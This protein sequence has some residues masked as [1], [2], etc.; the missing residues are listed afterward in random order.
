M[1]RGAVLGPLAL[2]AVLLALVLLQGLVLREERQ[3]R[4]IRLDGVGAARVHA[5]V[6]RAHLRP[7]REEE[8]DHDHVGVGRGVEQGREAVGRAQRASS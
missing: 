5:G 4:A 3:Q 1:L 7:R 2:P 6:V 8:L